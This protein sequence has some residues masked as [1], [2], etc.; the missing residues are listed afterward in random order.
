MSF[1]ISFGIPFGRHERVLEAAVRLVGLRIR[2]RSEPHDSCPSPCGLWASSRTAFVEKEDPAPVFVLLLLLLVVLLVFDHIQVLEGLRAGQASEVLASLADDLVQQ[3]LAAR[4]IDHIVQIHVVLRRLGPGEV[5]VRVAAV[6]QVAVA[7]R[8]AEEGRVVLGD[9]SEAAVPDA[10]MYC[11]ESSSKRR[12]SSAAA[13]A[14]S[15]SVSKRCGA[16]AKV[17]VFSNF[18]V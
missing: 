14:A 2:G 5:Q 4:H 17:C 16:A 9:V 1:S 13:A 15:A 10:A 18:E 11:C 7:L 3:R 8:Q 6:Q 12:A